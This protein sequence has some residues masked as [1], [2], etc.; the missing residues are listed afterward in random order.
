M[1][2]KLALLALALCALVAL[3]SCGGT[4]HLMGPQV[5]EKAPVLGRNQPVDGGRRFAGGERDG[6]PTGDPGADQAPSVAPEADSLRTSF[7]VQ[8]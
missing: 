1:F 3:E 7:D 5:T 6:D 8:L 4:N 2:R